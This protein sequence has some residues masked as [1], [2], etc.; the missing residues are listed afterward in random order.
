MILAQLK[1]ILTNCSVITWLF[2]VTLVPVNHG[3]SRLIQNVFQTPR[4]IPFRSN[5]FIF[6]SSGEYRNAFQDIN[7]INPNYNYK[8]YTTWEKEQLVK[9][10]LEIRWWE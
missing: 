6:D 2:S 8:F 5:F 1:S 4:F 10:K 3:V 9:L 7:K